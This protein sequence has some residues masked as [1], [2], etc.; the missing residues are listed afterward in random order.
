MSLLASGNETHHNNGGY[1]FSAEAPPTSEPTD[2]ALVSR[3][4]AGDKEALE[5]LIRRHQPWVFNVAF[6]MLW[7]RDA[8][9]DAT[10]EILIKVV[11]KLSTYRHQSRFRTWLYR[12]AANHLL[13]A[14]KSDLER[15]TT[16]FSEMGHGLDETPDLELPD[17][18]AIPVDLPLLVEEA[19][20]GCMT[21]MLLC[22][23]RRQRLAFILGELCGA[24]SPVGAEVM[25]VSPEN[26]RQLLSRARHDLYQFMNEK[27]GLVNLNNPCRCAKKTRAFMEAGYIDPHQLQFTARRLARV[28]DVAPH[29]LNELQALNRQHGA[30]FRDHGFLQPKD[31]ASELRDLITRSGVAVGVDAQ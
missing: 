13:N 22:L 16:T 8:A 17:P 31:L 20:V 27:C 4:Q 15:Q 28:R 3:A 26:F 14:R 24:P 9:E 6:R 10:Q 19:R 12:V 18:R 7:H 29:R 2:E 25:G 23:D 1:P 30:L 5:Q 11:T 21:A